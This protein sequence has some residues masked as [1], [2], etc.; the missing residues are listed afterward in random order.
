MAKV[1]K[2]TV[3]Y[4][5]TEALALKPSMFQCISVTV[6]QKALKQCFDKRPNFT[7]TQSRNVRSES[8]GP[9]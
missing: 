6:A 4:N 1:G 2:P 7:L 9:T 5:I 8:R 3:I